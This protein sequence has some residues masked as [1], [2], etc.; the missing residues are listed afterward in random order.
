[1]SLAGLLRPTHE[2]RK[3]RRAKKMEA[4]RRLFTYRLRKKMAEAAL[5]RFG[6]DER[7]SDGKLVPATLRAM[8]IARKRERK[9]VRRIVPP[10]SRGAGCSRA[11]AL[12]AAGKRPRF[13]L[14]QHAGACSD[15]RRLAGG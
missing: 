11:R 1:V 7:T 12:I 13:V 8:R 2:T 5:E 4:R 14:R 10:A 6:L 15:C 9:I 3:Q